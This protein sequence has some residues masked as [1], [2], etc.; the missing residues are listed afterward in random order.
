MEQFNQVDIVF[1]LSEMFLEEVVNGR[2]NHE[3]VVDCNVSH[4][5]LN[6]QLDSVD[7]MFELTTRYQHG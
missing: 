1:L 5:W 4:F 7:G 3:C 6:R 2:F